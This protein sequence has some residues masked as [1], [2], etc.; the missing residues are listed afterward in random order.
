[1]G[2]R[3]VDPLR[4]RDFH[5]AAV[6][7]RA[8]MDTAEMPSLEGRVGLFGSAAGLMSVVFALAWLEHELPLPA[9][10]EDRKAV[11]WARSPDGLVGAVLV[12]GPR[13]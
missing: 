10:P 8:A 11:A 9:P 6:R 2:P 5:L 4:T 7:H 1:V 12:G 13:S 3:D